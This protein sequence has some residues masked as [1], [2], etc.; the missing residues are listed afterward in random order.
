MQ[1]SDKQTDLNVVIGQY[2]MTVTKCIREIKPD[3]K[4]WQRSFHDHVI[5]NQSRYEKIW[6]YIEDNPRKWEE[7]CFYIADV[8]IE[9]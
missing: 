7:D 4:V 5:R 6:N 1:E 3:C 8:K 9:R 2:K